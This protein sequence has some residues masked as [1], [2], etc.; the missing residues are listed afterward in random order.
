M[1]EFMLN[2]LLLITF[3][4]SLFNC[5]LHLWNIING[6]REDIPKKYEISSVDRFLLGLSISYII[7][8]IFTG[9]QIQ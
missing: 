8:T 1:G 2:K 4:M 3:I 6:L 7:T 5:I 9:L